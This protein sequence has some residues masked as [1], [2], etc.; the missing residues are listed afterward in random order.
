M[1][2][3]SERAMG[4][5]KAGDELRVRPS[6]RIWEAGGDRS[7]RVLFWLVFSLALLFLA[8]ATDD[9]V[10]KVLILKSSAFLKQ[11]ALWA[12]KSGEGWVIACTGAA[13]SLFLFLRHRFAASRIVFLVAGTG[14]LTGGAATIIR[15][16]L[17]RTRPTA[18]ELQ[19]FY[20]VWHDSHWIIGQYEFGSFPSGHA[21][22]V[23]GIAAAAWLVDRR[24]GILAALYAL[25]VSWSRIALGCHHFSDLVAAG[26]LGIYGAHLVSVRLGPSVHFF[27][28]VLQKAWLAR[29]R[30]V[31]ASADHLE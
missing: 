10:S 31:G 24:F 30:P 22:T 26:I 29:K 6:R 16:L 2:K 15:S 20:G 9:L 19:G 12:S 28:Q 7:L 5:C 4:P 27:G 11:L 14:L 8:F 1:L 13:I 3:A 25:L 21:A 18:H 23:I 17:G